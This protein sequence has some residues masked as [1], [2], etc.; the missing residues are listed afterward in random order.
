MTVPEQYARKSASELATIIR[1]DM[2]EHA[3]QVAVREL[4]RR[5]ELLDRMLPRDWTDYAAQYGV[6]EA[7]ERALVS[8]FTR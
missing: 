7:T 5:S 8:G 3:K 4:E 1:L 6:R 2:N